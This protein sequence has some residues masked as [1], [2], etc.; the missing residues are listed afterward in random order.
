MS[1][2]QLTYEEL[3]AQNQGSNSAEIS[4]RMGVPFPL[5][6]DAWII[7]SQNTFYGMVHYVSDRI[8]LLNPFF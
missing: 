7:S 6:L 1:K 3:F 8:L 2:I 4:L 5:V